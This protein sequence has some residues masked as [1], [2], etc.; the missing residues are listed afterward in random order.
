MDRE[1]FDSFCEFIESSFQR[2]STEMVDLNFIKSA[3]NKI[4]TDKHFI[5]IIG[6][7]SKDK[8]GRIMIEMTEETSK[9]ITETMNGE[10]FENIFD[11]SLYLAEFTNIFCGNAVTLINDKY[12]GTDLRLTPAAVLSGSGIEITTPNILSK[13]NFYESANNLVSLDIGFEGM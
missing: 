7:V 9:A 6:A 4:P 2:I 12:P 13:T 5:V 3:K 11:L 10:P 8:K 1:K